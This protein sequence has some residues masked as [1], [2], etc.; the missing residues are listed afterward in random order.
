M[1]YKTYKPTGTSFSLSNVF[2]E[3]HERLSIQT[4]NSHFR[5]GNYSLTGNTNPN[6]STNLIPE[7]SR[8]H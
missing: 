4:K 6:Q 2:G 5:R 1:E 7:A 3:A 8:Q